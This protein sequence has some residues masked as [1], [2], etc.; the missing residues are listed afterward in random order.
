MGKGLK[1]EELEQRGQSTEDLGRHL[2]KDERETILG[3]PITTRPV[4]SARNVVTLARAQQARNAIRIID[5]LVHSD[6]PEE[7]HLFNF[8]VAE[9]ISDETGDLG[10]RFSPLPLSSPSALMFLVVRSSS[11]TQNFT[12]ITAMWYITPFVG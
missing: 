11:L 2:R 1:S 7:I 8:F 10:M 12:G 9:L 4:V 3:V 6:D 5:W